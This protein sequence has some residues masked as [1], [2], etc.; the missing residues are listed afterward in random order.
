MLYPATLWQEHKHFS[1]DSRETSP[2]RP[3]T[4]SS[5]GESDEGLGISFASFGYFKQLP[6]RIG[7]RLRTR[8]SRFSGH[9]RRGVRAAVQ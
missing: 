4:T 8:F 9:P 3:H 1:R 6:S 2:N 5:R 7:L